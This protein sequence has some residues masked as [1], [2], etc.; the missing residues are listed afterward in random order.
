MI[1]LTVQKHSF[2]R[3]ST[4]NGRS[5][6]SLT[7]AR[8]GAAQEWQPDADGFFHFRGGQLFTRAQRCAEADKMLQSL[9]TD[10]AQEREELIHCETSLA[11]EAIQT[12][13]HAANEVVLFCSVSAS[14]HRLVACR[15]LGIPCR[16]LVI[17]EYQD[18]SCRVL[19]H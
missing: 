17:H 18:W 19:G 10:F 6:S 13:T 4:R 5:L 15:H 12:G 9:V 11:F 14:H 1:H 2:R 3:P 16:Y 8:S 7:G